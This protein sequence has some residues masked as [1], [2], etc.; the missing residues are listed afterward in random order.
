[1][2]KAISGVAAAAVCAAMLGVPAAASQNYGFLVDVTLSPKAAALLHAKNEGIK[3][4]AEYMGDPVTGKEAKASGGGEI[5]LGNEIVTIPGASGR[6][7]I[8]GKIVNASR[9]PW[10]KEFDVNINVFTARRSSPDNLIDCDF[11][12]DAVTKAQA[13]PLAI[14]CKLIGEK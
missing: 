12:Q 5:E 8:T 7:I 14:S 9:I 11:F 10:V 1:M 3:V 2:I 13:K 4:S 6:A